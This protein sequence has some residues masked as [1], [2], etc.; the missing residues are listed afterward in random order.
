MKG[1]TRSLIVVVATFLLLCSPG[2]ADA[3]GLFFGAG[4]G[5]TTI[6]RSLY[7]LCRSERRMSGPS[8]SAQAGFRTGRLRFAA[9]LDATA[10]GYEDAADCVPRTGTSTDTSFAPGSSGVVTASGD[11]WFHV[12]KHLGVSA[13]AGWVPNHGA[14]FLST[15][16]GAQ[17]RKIRLE[18][19]ARRHRASFDAITREFGSG[20][21][22]EIGRSSHTEGSW[23]G[24]VRLMLVTR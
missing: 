5:A 9:G 14:W 21:T 8:V 23:G 4:V 24:L 13:G 15:G 19:V 2:W 22:R 10:R 11:A 17:F 6:P 18:M 1:S 16:V 7:A 20:T 3:Q 12:A